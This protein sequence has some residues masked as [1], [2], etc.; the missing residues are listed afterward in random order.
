MAQGQRRLRRLR[1][2]ARSEAFCHHTIQRP[3]TT[4]VPD[5]TQDDRFAANPAVVGDLRVRFYAG[6]PLRA[7]GGEPVGALCIVDTEP[8]ELT[9]SQEAVLREMARIVEHELAADD[10]P[11]VGA[12]RRVGGRGPRPRGG[13][14]Q[15]AGGQPTRMKTGLEM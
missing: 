2:G 3:G 10:G 12:G 5:A 13:T 14:R 15:G 7:P 9:T 4:V 1:R 6:E 11:G 8:R